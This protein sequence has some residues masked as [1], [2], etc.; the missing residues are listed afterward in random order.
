MI[1]IEFLYVL[2]PLAVALTIY[3]VKF[4]DNRVYANIIMGGFSSSILWFYLAGNIITGNIFYNFTD[5][6][7]TFIDVSFFWV[8]VL[9]GIIITL[10]SL[11]LAIEAIFEKRM[12]EVIGGEV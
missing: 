6:T 2:A 4:Y 12:D 10:Y 8:F 9:M 3:A 7:D 5:E 1:P 11:A